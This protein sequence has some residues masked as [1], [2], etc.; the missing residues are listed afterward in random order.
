MSESGAGCGNGR[1]SISHV[2][3][4]EIVFC[5]PTE[6]VP[7]YAAFHVCARCLNMLNIVSPGLF[8]K[9][10]SAEFSGPI[11]P[12]HAAEVSFWYL[13]FCGQDFYFTCEMSH[14]VEPEL[15]RDTAFVY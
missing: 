11:T 10:K 12:D 13:T 14:F 6:P 3:F 8:Q 15:Q 5:P 4:A 2:N 7:K 1:K 9:T